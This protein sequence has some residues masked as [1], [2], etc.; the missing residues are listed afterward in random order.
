MCVPLTKA[1]SFWG[2]IR[3]NRK[4]KKGDIALGAL[5]KQMPSMHEQEGMRPVV[6]VGMLPGRTRYWLVMVAPLTTQ[7]GQWFDMNPIV[8]PLLSAGAGNLNRNSVV[9]LDQIRAIDARRL[10]QYIG[11]L[12]EDE[13]SPIENGISRIFG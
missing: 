12:S 1:P 6:V 7:T 8:Y 11:R 9:L 13:F 10:R 5:P 3:L 4:L 2:Q